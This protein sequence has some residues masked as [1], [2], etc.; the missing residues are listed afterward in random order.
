MYSTVLTLSLDANG[1]PMGAAKRLTTS[2]AADSPSAW[3]SDN[4]TV[5]FQSTRSG[6]PEIFRQSDP[7]EPAVQLSAGTGDK[8]W[9]RA[10]STG[11][12]VLYQVLPHVFPKGT[13]VVTYAAPRPLLRVAAT[14]GPPELVMQEPLVLSHRCARLL[15][16]CFISELNSAKDRLVFSIIDLE[17][18]KGRELATFPV[19]SFAHYSWDVSGDGTRIAIARAGDPHIRILSLANGSV[20][21]I[22]VDGWIRHQGLDWASDSQ[23]LFIGT[24]TADGTALL[25]VDL[26]GNVRTV[27]RQAGGLR[28]S[29]IQS[30]DGRH[31]AV[32]GWIRHGNVWEIE[33]H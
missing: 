4:R 18:G 14:G 29:G 13:N 7:S 3:L 30:P 12:W 2:D 19:D 26:K 17:H 8:Y 32:L 16:R 9:G 31:L 21:D 10:T 28:T 20:Q 27:W 1:M 15:D 24:A 11:K 6:Q 22:P 5:V 23:G 33:N 25:H